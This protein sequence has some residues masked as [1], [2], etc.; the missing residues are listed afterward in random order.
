MRARLCVRVRVFLRLCVCFRQTLHHHHHHHHHTQSQSLRRPNH[1][2][3]QHLSL[4]D[5]YALTRPA[6]A[7]LDAVTSWLPAHDIPYTVAHARRIRASM[8][9]PVAADLFG[10]EF[11]VLSHPGS[12]VSVTRAGAYTLPDSVAS[13][14]AAVFGLHGLP[15]PTHAPVP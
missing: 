5:I 6:Q 11:V 14:T 8:P 9:V 1:R 15:L 12:N 13:A 3:G 2:Y 10:T 7:H 4:E